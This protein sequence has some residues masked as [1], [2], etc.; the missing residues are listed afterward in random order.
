MDLFDQFYYLPT[1][2][3]LFSSLPLTFAQRIFFLSLWKK[4]NFFPSQ[5]W[6]QQESQFSS[7][8][9]ASAECFISNK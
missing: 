3:Q 1:S 8:E 2:L 5:G 6:E 7:E 4:I 9:A